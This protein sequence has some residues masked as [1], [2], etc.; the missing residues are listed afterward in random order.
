MRDAGLEGLRLELEEGEEVEGVVEGGEEGA[1]T[2]GGG[3]ESGGLVRWDALS[4]IGLETG[5]THLFNRKMILSGVL[6]MSTSL[7]ALFSTSFAMLMSRAGGMASA[8]FST[9]A[10][11]SAV[12]SD[13]VLDFHV[14]SSAQLTASF[15]ECFLMMGNGSVSEVARE[16]FPNSASSTPASP[17]EMW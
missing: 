9:G 10:P 15:G 11:G 5:K 7:G 8:W 16:R 14:G 3:E 13:M 1:E 17:R 4:C 6:A 2:A 12:G